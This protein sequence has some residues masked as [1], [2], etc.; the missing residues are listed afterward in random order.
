[1]W[2]DFFED[3]RDRDRV[4]EYA[5]P[6]GKRQQHLEDP[7]DACNHEKPAKSVEYE[8]GSEDLLGQKR[9][10]GRRSVSQSFRT[11]Q[12]GPHEEQRMQEHRP[13]NELP[14]VRLG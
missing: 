12:I 2:E 10:N 9:E 5:H 13:D 4:G 7:Q 6:G 14:D 8:R 3:Q 11:G 1:M